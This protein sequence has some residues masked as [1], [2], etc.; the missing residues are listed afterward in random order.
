MEEV[1]EVVT[2][3]LSQVTVVVL[4]DKAVVSDGKLGKQV[5]V[6]PSLVTV[7]VTVAHA[8]V[9]LY[10]SRSPHPPPGEAATVVRSK[11]A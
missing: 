1:L 10:L 5:L 3:V 7:T 9:Y 8:I 2:L 4:V 6:P 11:A